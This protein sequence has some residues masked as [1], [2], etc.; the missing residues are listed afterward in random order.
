MSIKTIKEIPSKTMKK[1]SLLLIILSLLF[2]LFSIMIIAISIGQVDIPF[3]ETFMVILQKIT[4]IKLSGFDS[5]NPSYGNIIWLIR[6]PRVITACLIGMG[7]ALCGTIMQASVQNP[8]ADPYIL[9]VSSGASLGATFSILI[10]FGALPLI[11]QVGIAFGA[12]IGALVAA[13]LV[14]LFANIGGR[15]TSTKLVLSGTVIDSMFTAFSS[16]IIYFSSN[17]QGLQSVTFWMMGSVASSTWANIPLLFS[18][19]I[20]STAFFITQTRNLNV[21]LL[22][23]EQAT[24]LGIHLPFYR[25]LYLT[26]ASLI[27]GIMVA[28]CGMIGFVGLII[29]HITRAIIGS[30]HK[31]LLPISIVFGG[32]FMVITDL[33]ARSIIPGAEIPVGIITAAVGAP[34]F[35]YM[36]LKKNYGFGGN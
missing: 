27:T 15:L 26:I 9:G 8:L 33:L 11:G 34:V 10:G 21:M 28:N 18:I 29:P 35:L 36:L 2:I 14:L 5:L 12:F 31:K 22:G 32:I 1:N 3:Y 23:D 17:M 16:M 6:M 7:L 30:D 19:I 4:G 24:T 13:I 25:K 20:I